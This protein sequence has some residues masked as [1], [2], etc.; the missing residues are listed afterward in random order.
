[1]KT[2]HRRHEGHVNE[3]VLGAGKTNPAGCTAPHTC[4]GHDVS[5]AHGRTCSCYRTADTDDCRKKTTG[6]RSRNPASAITVTTADSNSRRPKISPVWRSEC[7][8]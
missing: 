6:P 7:I 5:H 1:M 8:R 3:H 4:A 2:N